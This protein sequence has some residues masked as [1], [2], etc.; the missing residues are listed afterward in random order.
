MKQNAFLKGNEEILEAYPFH[1]MITELYH[2]CAL[3][4]QHQSS[5]IC[6]NSFLKEAY[7]RRTSNIFY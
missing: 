6:F 4:R 2:L 1:L 7:F 5:H 3:Y